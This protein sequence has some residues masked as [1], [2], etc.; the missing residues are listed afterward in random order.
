MN[1]MC[2][3]GVSTGHLLWVVTLVF[4]IQLAAPTAAMA[5]QC[6]HSLT[7]FQEFTPPDTGGPLTSGASGT[8]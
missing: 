7:V 5:C 3:A 6:D 2:A 1:V 8:R 4:G